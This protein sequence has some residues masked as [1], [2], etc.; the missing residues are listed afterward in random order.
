MAVLF[1]FLLAKKKKVDLFD[2]LCCVVY[3]MIGALIVAKLLFVLVSLREIIQLKL[4][5]IEVIKGGFVFY[6]GLLGGALG[7]WIYAKQFR[8]PVRGYVDIFAAVLPLGH[9]CGRVGCFFAG[10]CYGMEYDG[11]CSVVYKTSTTLLTPL[12]VPLLPIQLIEAACL[13]VLFVVLMLL[14]CK[15]KVKEGNLALIYALSYAVLRFILEF[16]RGDKER[17]V[18]LLSTSQYISLVIVAVVI[19]LLIRRKKRA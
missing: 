7:I 12:G 11:C 2:F 15:A 14:L 5:I 19:F 10:C 9:A 1:G 6:G 13:V 16:F 8:T 4:N 17:G 3:T 18:F